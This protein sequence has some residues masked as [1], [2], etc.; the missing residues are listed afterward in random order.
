LVN[1]QWVVTAAHCVDG[2]TP[3]SVKITTG[4]HDKGVGGDNAVDHAVSKIIMHANYNGNGNGFPNDIA[5]MKL[6]SPI[7]MNEHRT[8]I[9]LADSDEE[10]TGTSCF[11][12]GWGDTKGTSDADTLNQ[13]AVSV[14]EQRECI[15]AWGSNYINNGHICV[16]TGSEGACNG[17]SG[18]PL[19][20]QKQGRWILAGATS[21]GYSGCQTAGYPS[22]YSRISYFRDWIIDNIQSN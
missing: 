4:E 10:F 16:G 1:D 13:L 20:C 17:D 8:P 5:L 7:S 14:W 6:S 9:C 12:T 2:D 3:S 19:A 22:V 21:W 15:D 18:G 11:I